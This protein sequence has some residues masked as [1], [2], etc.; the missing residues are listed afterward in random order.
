MSS[1][2]FTRNQL[3]R[4]QTS[5][6]PQDNLK[7]VGQSHHYYKYYETETKPQTSQSTLRKCQISISK[8]T[9]RG[10]SECSYTPKQ[11]FKDPPK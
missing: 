10:K 4:P 11:D 7:I 5:L 2:Q 9:I 1:V 8:H 3:K 6:K